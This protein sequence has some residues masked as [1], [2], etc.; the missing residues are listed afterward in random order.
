MNG[1]QPYTS[2]LNHD[3]AYWMARIAKAL[4]EKSPNQGAP[5]EARILDDLRAEDTG[6]RSV[7]GQ[8]KHSAQAAL[9][10]HEDYLC[11]AFRGT[12][13]ISDWLDNANALPKRALFGSFHRGFCCSV[14]DIW[15]PLFDVYQEFKSARA[16]PLFITGHSLGGAMA[17]IA[18]SRLIYDDLPFTSTYTF[19]QPR[20]MTLD[21]ARIF[22]SDA[23]QRVFR[24]VN[25]ND[26]VTR[27]P[28]RTMG[29]SHVGTMLYIAEDGKIHNDPGFWFRFIDSQ[30]G[31]IAELKK[32][33]IDAID[34][35][36]IDRYLD[37][38]KRWDCAC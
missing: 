22:N 34:D 18:A 5:D 12:D 29:Y 6:F 35:H 11:M 19:G 8:S 25:N 3:N 1:V 16:R 4:Y 31:A 2:V 20:A 17:T 13:E 36:S 26:I 9:V 14:E 23:K 27:V 32:R 38:V 30:G 24:F 33:G 7:C 21:T 37:A 10:E 28:T 15:Q